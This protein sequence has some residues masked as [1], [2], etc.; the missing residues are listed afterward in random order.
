MR[1]KPARVARM[2]RACFPLKGFGQGEIAQLIPARIHLGTI[3]PDARSRFTM[4]PHVATNNVVKM[5]VGG[6]Q[7]LSQPARLLMTEVRQPVVAQ[8]IFCRRIRLTVAHQHDFCHLFLPSFGSLRVMPFLIGKAN[9][10]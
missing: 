6:G 10:R 7:M 1:D 3:E 9:G 5:P 4:P 8:L 2:G